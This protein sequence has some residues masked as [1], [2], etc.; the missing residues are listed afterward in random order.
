MTE[1]SLEDILFRE[2]KGSARR[3]SLK[4]K[5]D[6]VELTVEP[7]DYMILERR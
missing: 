5:G 2:I 3:P 1:K 7:Y 6:E 4:V